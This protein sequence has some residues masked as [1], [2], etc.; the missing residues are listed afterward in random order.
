[1]RVLNHMRHRVRDE[2]GAVLVWVGV[3]IV[4]LLGFAAFAVDLGQAYAVKRQLSV[5]ADGAALAGAQEAGLKYKS[6]GGCSS[7]LTNAAVGAAQ[8]NYA[9]SVP[10]G[11]PESLPASAVDVTC[12]ESSENAVTGEVT[13]S[14][15]VDTTFGQVLGV[16][17]MN[18]GAAAT[19]DVFGARQLGGLRPFTVC[20]EDARDAA[21]NGATHQSAYHKQ[22]SAP[23]GADPCNPS[24]SPGNWGYATFGLGTDDPTLLC[25][26][27]EGYGPECGGSEGGV[28]VGAPEDPEPSDGYAGNSIQGNPNTETADVRALNSLLG[29]TI[30]LPVSGDWTDGSGRNAEYL[31]MGAIAV[32]FCGWGMPKNNDQVLDD[33]EPHKTADCW[34]PA[35]YAA[36]TANWPTQQDIPSLVIQWRYVGEWVTSSVG[37]DPASGCELGD[38]TCIPALRLIQ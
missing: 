37:Q 11:G 15:E 3:M 25:L 19:A 33:T 32:E 16:A 21:A 7:S 24:G 14:G 27:E 9:A 28:D 4:V 6:L 18:P 29:Q 1:M 38:A 10:Q 2:S 20:L 34:D 26:I 13:V 5:V 8:A 22:N 35:L 17:T 23:E 30:L 12:D 36:S 31:G